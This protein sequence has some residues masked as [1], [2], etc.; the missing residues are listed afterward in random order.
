MQVTKVAVEV[1]QDKGLVAWLEVVKAYQACYAAL[2]REF[3]PLDLSVAQHD[4]LVAIYNA[5]GVN[6]QHL[7]EKLLVVKS[8][9]TA[10]LSRL[11]TRG[12]VLREV[13]T[14]DARAKQVYLT[15]EG[16]ALVEKSLERQRV[17]LEQMVSALDVDEIEMLEATMRRVR[18]RLEAGLP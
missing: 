5:D 7:A 12:L 11:E 14:Q 15:P 1:E 6:Q 18:G 10:L 17:V 13:D 4:M 9:V 3:K 8:N 16:R 2:S